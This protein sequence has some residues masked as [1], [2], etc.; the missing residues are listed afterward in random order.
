MTLEDHTGFH[1]LVIYRQVFQRYRQTILE[2][3]VLLVQGILEK[4]DGVIN[5]KVEKVTGIHMEF[6]RQKIQMR[7][8]R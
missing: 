7:D 5:I 1:N 4:A 8:F 2:E 6:A 3:P